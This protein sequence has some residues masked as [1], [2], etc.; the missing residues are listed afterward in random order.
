MHTVL[1]ASIFASAGVALVTTLLIEYF[2]KPGLEAR[3]DRILE[4]RRDQR[5]ALKDLR[6]YARLAG[7][8]WGLARDGLIAS[9]NQSI[10]ELRESVRKRQQRW[11]GVWQ[12]Y[13]EL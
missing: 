3:K 5:N 12:M 9:D 11:T 7:E 6:L 8:M 1:W 4:D 10:A 2:A 13:I